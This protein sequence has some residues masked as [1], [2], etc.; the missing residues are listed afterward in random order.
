MNADNPGEV[1]VRKSV[2]SAEETYQLLRR[3]TEPDNLIQSDLPKE[4]TPEGL[5]PKR[6]WYLYDNI[7][8]HIPSPID[9]DLT[10]PLPKVERPKNT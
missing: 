9:K 10:A 4:I 6:Q 5:S 2:D 7:R 8:M 3:D 1:M